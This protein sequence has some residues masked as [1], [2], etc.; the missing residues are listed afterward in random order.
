M[1]RLPV[2]FLCAS[3]VNGQICQKT[4]ATK[5]Q[6]VPA[7]GGFISGIAPRRHATINNYPWI[8]EPIIDYNVVKELLKRC[9]Q[10]TKEVGHL[11]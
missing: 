3:F 4:F 5:K 2:M 10:I 11:Y 9:E 1:W 6:T 7:F 8:P